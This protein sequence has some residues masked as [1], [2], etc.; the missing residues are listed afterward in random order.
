[1]GWIEVLELELSQTNSRFLRFVKFMESKAIP[2]EL[3][4]ESTAGTLEE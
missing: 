1:M 2:D 3:S 4:E